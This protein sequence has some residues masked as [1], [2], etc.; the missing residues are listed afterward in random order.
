[1]VLCECCVELHKWKI[2]TKHLVF[3]DLFSLRAQS[4]QGKVLGRRAPANFTAPGR[5]TLLC[6]S[7][8]IFV[9]QKLKSKWNML[10]L[11]YFLTMVV[12]CVSATVR[13]RRTKEFTST[14]CIAAQIGLTCNERWFGV[15]PSGIIAF[16]LCVGFISGP[17]SMV[18]MNS[19]LKR[20]S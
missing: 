18:W 5:H 2:H 10:V 7:G 8:S 6:L 3:T 11:S 16:W 20:W 17:E 9:L 15:Y 19:V 1:M 12:F 14:D 4:A 13:P